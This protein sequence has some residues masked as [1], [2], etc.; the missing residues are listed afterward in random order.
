MTNSIMILN[1]RLL[2]KDIHLAK[3]VNYPF[4]PP[5]CFYSF[6]PPPL[7]LIMKVVFW[8]FLVI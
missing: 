7:T 3:W 5:P 2:Y 8:I 6:C 4:P 1:V